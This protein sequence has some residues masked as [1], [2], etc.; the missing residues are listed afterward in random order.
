MLLLPKSSYSRSK[1]EKEKEMDNNKI[2]NSFQVIEEGTEKYAVI[3]MSNYDDQADDDTNDK[4]Q[5]STKL[6]PPTSEEEEEESIYRPPHKQS[7]STKPH[8]LQPS[9]TSI[10]RPP[11]HL[12]QSSSS[13]SSS[14]QLIRQYQKNKKTNSGYGFNSLSSSSST[15]LFT[16]SRFQ[17]FPPRRKFSII[18]YSIDDIHPYTYVREVFERLNWGYIDKFIYHYSKQQQQQKIWNEQDVAKGRLEEKY[19]QNT[20]QLIIHYSDFDCD[21]VFDELRSAPKMVLK[22]KHFRNYVHVVHDFPHGIW[23]VQEF[24]L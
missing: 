7:S 2:P 5:P 8:L 6:F 9:E 21:A 19:V 16:N 18:I 1:K 12:Q 17:P 24:L 4:P 10:Y 20:K 3:R 14:S 23:K 15:Q 13:S 22:N 11:H